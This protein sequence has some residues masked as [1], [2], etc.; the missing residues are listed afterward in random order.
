MERNLVKKSG[1]PA[2]NATQTFNSVKKKFDSFLF[3]V[4]FERLRKKKLKGQKIEIV[5][6]LSVMF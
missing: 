6:N 1:N 2:C 5:E 4:V 3:F